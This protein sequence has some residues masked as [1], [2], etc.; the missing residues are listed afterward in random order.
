MSS[1][2]FYIDDEHRLVTVVVE[3]EV[4]Q[5]AGEEII[6]K[7]REQATDLGYNIFYDMRGATTTV[8]FVNWYNLPRDL[9]VFHR[10]G[11]RKIKVAVMISPTDKALE[12]YKFYESVT[13]NLGFKLRIF[14]DESEAFRWLEN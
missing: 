12:G 5:N 14:F 8:D 11:A 1:Y 6:T 4:F 2:K 7:A 13:D 3:G 9:D 10:S